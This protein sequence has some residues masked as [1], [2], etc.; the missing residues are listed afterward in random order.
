MAAGDKIFLDTDVV[1]D[2]LAD[3]QPFSEYAHRLFALA[4]QDE[5]TLCISALSFSNLY[6]ILRKLKNGDEALSLLRKLKGLVKVTL[7]GEAE[8]KS[9]LGQNFKDFEDALQCFSAKTE[10]DM[11]VII[12]RNKFDF[13]KNLIRVESPEEFLAKRKDDTR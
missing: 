12:T 9:T 5:I 1:L 6:Y 13:P 11:I 8:V 3:R 10:K 4:E 2:H 7:V